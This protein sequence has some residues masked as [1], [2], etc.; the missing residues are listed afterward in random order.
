MLH[1]EQDAEDVFQATFLVLAR[2]AGSIRNFESVGSW[3]HGVAYQLSRN[4]QASSRRRGRLHARGASAMPDAD[5]LLDLTVRELHAA[6]SDELQRLPEKYRAPLVLCYLEGQSHEEAACQL[7]LSR[8]S[9]RGRLNRAREALR[10]RLARRGLTISAGFLAGALPADVSARSATLVDGTVRAA[11][12]YAAGETIAGGLVSANAVLLAETAIKTTLASKVVLALILLLGAGLAATASALAPPPAP[13]SV[14]PVQPV[15]QAARRGVLEPVRFDPFAVH[16]QPVAREVWSV[17]FSPDSKTVASVSDRSARP[18]ELVL[19]DVHTRKPRHRVRQHGARAV[20]FSPNGQAV[21]V[22]NY[23]DRTVRIYDVSNGR[24]LRTLHGHASGVNSLAYSPD[25][26]TLATA[27][28]DR[29]SR[30]WNTIDGQLRAT[31][32]GH[33]DDGVYSVAVSPNGKWVASCGF[34][35]TA[36]VWDLVTGRMLGVLQGHREPV[37]SVAFAPD[38]MLAT[39]SWD[40]TIKLWDTSGTL[41]ATLEGH[42]LPVLSIAFSSDG[43]LLVSGSGKWGNAALPDQGGEV[44]LWDVARRKELAGL[45]GHADR[46]W[47]VAFARDGKTVASAG[48]DQTIRLWDVNARKEQAVLRLPEGKPF[49][50]APILASA[51]SSASEMLAVAPEN[52]TISLIDTK[53]GELMRTVKA[54]DE[55]IASLAFSPDGHV[56]ASGGTD[57]IVRLW[58]VQTGKF[59]RKLEGH[60]SWVY[61]LAFS[62]DGAMLASGGFDKDV[63]LWSVATGKEQRVSRGHTASVRAVAFSRDGRSLASAGSDRRVRIW[64]LVGKKATAVFRG[65]TGFIRAVAFA[66]DGSSIASTGEDGTVRVWDLA[67][68]NELQTLEPQKKSAQGQQARPEMTA[69]AFAPRGGWLAVGGEDG[70]VHLWDPVRGV[71][72][73]HLLSPGAIAGLAFAKDGRL[74]VTGND[75]KSRTWEPVVGWKKQA[76]TT[77]P[78]IGEPGWAVAFAPGGQTLAA[79]SGGTSGTLKVWD[80][81]TKK[82]RVSIKEPSMLRCVAFTPDGKLLATGCFDNTVQ[83]RDAVTGKTIRLLKGHTAGVNSLSFRRDG[84]ALLTGSLDRTAKLWDVVTGAEI[85]TF[86]GHTGEVFSAALSPDGKTAAT[87]G[88]DRVIKLWDVERCTV[89]LTLKGHGQPVEQAVFS[90]DGTTFASAGWDHTVR[91]WDVATGEMKRVL[92]NQECACLALAF[93]PDGRTLAIAN[94]DLV[95]ET[96]GEVSLWDLATGEATQ[97]LQGHLRGVRH[98]CFSPN[99]RR[100]ASMGEDG[101]VKMWEVGAGKG[102]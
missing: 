76:E 93:S 23:Y 50:P 22:A 62:G 75:G 84:R 74:I 24:L 40:R 7:G 16:V 41:I 68:G 25:G 100:L 61:A 8:G 36:R 26:S 47:S 54:S 39:A 80:V 67:T 13:R 12:R 11:I 3:L 53:T 72:R 69:L 21:A 14:Q 101:V 83:L 66:P 43:K 46:V 18:G 99:G 70:V 33:T 59:L 65:H 17:A 82:E 29:T 71:S 6:V 2:K 9:P 94:G 38:G 78:G 77:L 55:P 86:A 45:T 92:R 30:L 56:L 102:P 97:F 49:E 19:W 27:G 98:V 31:L 96:A 35:R 73:G 5:P 20:A 48:W 85:A 44:K 88:R 90:R 15:K 10:H 91:L 52:G 95:E 42:A 32:D 58:D 4:V 51:Y 1:H 64:D 79:V 60:A 89:K 63:R 28:L 87:V 37:E 34:D 81:A 57:N